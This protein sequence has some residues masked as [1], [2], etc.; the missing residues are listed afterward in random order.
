MRVVMSL[1]S[2]V[3]LMSSTPISAEILP[4]V[5][6][7]IIQLAELPYACQKARGAFARPCSILRHCERNPNNTPEKCEH[8]ERELFWLT[9]RPRECWKPRGRQLSQCRSLKSC[10]TNPESDEE[11]CRALSLK[12]TAAGSLPRACK[13]ASGSLKNHR[14]RLKNVVPTRKP[15]RKYAMLW[16][17]KSGGKRT[18]RQNAALRRLL[19]LPG[20]AL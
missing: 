13:R 1:F 5:Q 10:M 11:K 18:L 16:R 15:I 9:E 3:M 2:V 6:K 4:P 14:N 7:N 19:M 20:A 17:G 12:I 8:A